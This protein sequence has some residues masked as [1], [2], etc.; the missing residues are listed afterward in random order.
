MFA[1]IFRGSGK[2][3]AGRLCSLSSYTNLGLTTPNFGKGVEVCAALQLISDFMAQ[4]YQRQGWR[5]EDSWKAASC[6][7]GCYR[8]R[9]GGDAKGSRWLGT[10]PRPQADS[11]RESVVI[12]LVFGGP[13]G[14]GISDSSTPNI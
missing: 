10:A 11:E 6:R 5:V 9:L 12:M 8:V 3:V 2:S 13:S 1:E 4:S 14:P 7:L